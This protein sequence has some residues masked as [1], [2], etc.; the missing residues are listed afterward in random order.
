MQRNVI[1]VSF[2]TAFFMASPT[3]AQAYIG[4]G[5]GLGAVTAV[6]GVLAALL[7]AVVGLIWYPLK[8]MIKRKRSPKSVPDVE[9]QN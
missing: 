2:V 8:R 6:L 3:M 9:S 7:L 1:V 5:M 4:P